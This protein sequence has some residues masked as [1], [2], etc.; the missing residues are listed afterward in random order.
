MDFF[1]S[2]AFAQAATGEQPGLVGLIFPIGIL[3]IFFLLFIRPQQ[4]RQKEHKK[5]VAA[6][7]SGTEVVT[8]GGLLGKV[9]DLDDN[10]IQIEVADNIILQVQRHAIANLMPKG[11]YK[12]Q[13][14]KEKQKQL[15]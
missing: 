11:T 4:K 13:Q 7:S 2:N 5:M 6:L 14:K 10:F 9:I 12:V 1:I 3:A 15:S 8:N